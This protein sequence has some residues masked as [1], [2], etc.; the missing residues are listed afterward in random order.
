MKSGLE[1]VVTRS[2][3]T[4]NPGPSNPA[5][6]PEQPHHPDEGEQIILELR[7]ERTENP[8]ESEPAVSSFN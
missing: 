1:A 7:R 5:P 2:I 4:D 3:R 6:A 8:G